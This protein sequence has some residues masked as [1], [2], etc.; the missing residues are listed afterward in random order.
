MSSRSFTINNSYYIADCP[1]HGPSNHRS[2]D[3]KCVRCSPRTDKGIGADREVVERR[4]TIEDHQERRA[5]KADSWFG[6]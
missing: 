1:V 6:E 3:D 4:H 2:Q 5:E